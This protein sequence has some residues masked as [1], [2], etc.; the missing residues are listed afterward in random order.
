MFPEC[1]LNVP[2]QVPE[3]IVFM[4]LLEA[5]TLRLGQK[6]PECSLNVP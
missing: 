1:F 6:F 3:E 2:R 5:F 4:N